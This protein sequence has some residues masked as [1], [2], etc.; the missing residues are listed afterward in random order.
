MSRVFIPQTHTQRDFAEAEQF[1]DRVW[2]TSR[3]IND[4]RAGVIDQIV[5]DILD[6]LRAER[7]NPAEDYILMSGDLVVLFMFNCAVYDYAADLELAPIPIPLR[8]LKWNNRHQK[9]STIN[10]TL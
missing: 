6:T 2:C 7:F 5:Q 10:V 9:Y 1:G 8:L 4:E 3:H